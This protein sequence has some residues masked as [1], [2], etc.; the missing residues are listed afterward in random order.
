MRVCVCMDVCVCVIFVLHCLATQINFDKQISSHE[1]VTVTMVW[2][3]LVDGNGVQN[4]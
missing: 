2:G 4:G 3:Q 1:K